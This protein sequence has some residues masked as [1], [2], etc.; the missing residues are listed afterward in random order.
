MGLLAFQ[1]FVRRAVLGA[2]VSLSTPLGW[3]GAHPS[4]HGC[5]DRAPALALVLP[6]L[7]NHQAEVSL[8]LDTHS[9]QKGC[10]HA[11]PQAHLYQG[12]ALPQK[13]TKVAQKW[14]SCTE[15]Q[16]D[17][18]SGADRLIASGT[19]S[20]QRPVPLWSCLIAI[21]KLVAYR[22]IYFLGEKNSQAMTGDFF[23]VVVSKRS[24]FSGGDFSF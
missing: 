19:G 2:P 10:Q 1:H 21:T 13:R 22:Y 20:L 16:T 17:Q 6:P 24:S 7:G 11:S 12:K 4:R 8:Q 3:C 23:G 14:D 15:V 18:C 5:A 9:T